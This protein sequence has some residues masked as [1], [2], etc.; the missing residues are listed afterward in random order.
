MKDE[1]KK[2]FED[3]SDIKGDKK[4]CKKQIGEIY[5]KRYD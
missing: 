2:H 3:V 1:F 4:E 5:D